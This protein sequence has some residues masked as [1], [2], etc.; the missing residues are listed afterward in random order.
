MQTTTEQV[1]HQVQE[2]QH[3]NQQLANV[4]NK[5]ESHLKSGLCLTSA[6]FNCKQDIHRIAGICRDKRIYQENK[7]RNKVYKQKLRKQFPFN[8]FVFAWSDLMEK[9]KDAPS[10]FH[11]MSTAILI[12]PAVSDL[13]NEN[14]CKM[15]E[16]YKRSLFDDLIGWVHCENSESSATICKGFLGKLIFMEKVKINLPG[17]KQKIVYAID[18]QIYLK[19]LKGIST[20]IEKAQDKN[21]AQ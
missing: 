12:V 5:I 18:T 6:I 7:D 3:L 15:R 14:Q 1:N 13:I 21:A 19:D 17:G 20:F 10:G 16:V 8:A 2:G 9:V 4:C 11:V